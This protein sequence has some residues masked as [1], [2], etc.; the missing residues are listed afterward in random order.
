MNWKVIVNH[1]LVNPE[2]LYDA[3]FNV[4]EDVELKKVIIDAILE[5][6]TECVEINRQ[7]NNFDVFHFVTTIAMQPGYEPINYDVNVINTTRN[8]IATAAFGSNIE[9]VFVLQE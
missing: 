3:G 8:I 5:H 4:D 7:H 2:Q 1:K 9:Y 6:C